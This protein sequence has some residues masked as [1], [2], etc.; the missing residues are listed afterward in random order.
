MPDADALWQAKSESEWFKSLQEVSGAPHKRPPSL[1]DFFRRFLEAEGNFAENWNDTSA[2]QLRS[3]LHP[4]QSMVCHIRQL[5]SCLS[6]SGVSHRKTP[7]A[8]TRSATSARLNEV[9]SLLQQWYALSIQCVQ[10]STG[11][12]PVSCVSL[13]MYHLISLNTIICFVEIEQLAR[14]ERI[15]DVFRQFYSLQMC[16]I[17]R[18]QEIFFHCG[19]ILRLACSMPQ[20]VRPPWWPAA[21]YRVALISWVNSMAGVDARFQLNQSAPKESGN[22]FT[23]DTLEPENPSIYRYLKFR[24][25]IPI[26]SKRDGSAVSLSAAPGEILTHCVELLNEESTTRF[27]SGIKTRLEKLAERWKR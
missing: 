1:R 4:L 27:A 26:F 7:Q 18:A 9:Q 8:I 22:R 3:V 21:V 17:E 20:A 13:I 11:F 6:S 16:C 15:Q 19:Q 2:I 23:I 24:E 14:C 10:S 5:L 25:G 12:C